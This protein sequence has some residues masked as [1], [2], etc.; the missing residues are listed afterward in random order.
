MFVCRIFFFH[1]YESPRYLVHAG[2]PEDAVYVLQQITKVNGC[3]V[4]IEL[5]DVHDQILSGPGSVSTPRTFERVAI[6]DER[7]R[8]L[9][10]LPLL[11]TTQQQTIQHLVDRS[12]YLRPQHLDLFLVQFRDLQRMERT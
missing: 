1:L 7:L 6:V 3:S 11:R 5:E 8:S 2:R 12:V 9:M 10:I 4:L